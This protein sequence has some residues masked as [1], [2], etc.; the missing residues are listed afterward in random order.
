MHVLFRD[1]ELNTRQHKGAEIMRAIVVIAIMVYS[2]SQDAVH[3]I[4][5]A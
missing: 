3:S 4:D 5:L 2:S 1:L